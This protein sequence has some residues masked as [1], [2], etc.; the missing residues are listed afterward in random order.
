MQFWT[1][2]TNISLFFEFDKVFAEKNAKYWKGV[3]IDTKAYLWENN[4]LFFTIRLFV[5]TNMIFEL[6][7]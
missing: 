4:V 6:L 3:K 2:I 1:L 5:L 7:I